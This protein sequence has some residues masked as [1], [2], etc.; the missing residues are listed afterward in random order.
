MTQKRARHLFLELSRRLY[1]AHPDD[2]PNGFGG[3]AK[4]YRRA[5]HPN[6]AEANKIGIYSYRDA[7][8]NP[9]MKALRESVGM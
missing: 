7:W 9:T 3:I 6:W 5:W 2:F 4:H 1:E 8:E